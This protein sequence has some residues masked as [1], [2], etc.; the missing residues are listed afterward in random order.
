M[1]FGSTEWVPSSIH[2]LQAENRK[3]HKSNI[4]FNSGNKEKTSNLHTF[5]LER[6]TNVKLPVP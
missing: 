3:R 2:Q 5:L 4:C 1:R 6:V